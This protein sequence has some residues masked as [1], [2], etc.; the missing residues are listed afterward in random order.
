VRAIEQYGIDTWRAL[1]FP[2]PP[3]FRAVIDLIREIAR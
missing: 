1:G 3:K 2:L